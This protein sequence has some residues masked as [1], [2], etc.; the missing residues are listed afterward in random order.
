MRTKLYKRVYVWEFP[1]RLFHWINALAITVLVITGLFIADPFALMSNKEAY[2]TFLMGKFRFVHF[3]AAYILTGV[4]ILRL[5]WGF[6][7]NRY[8]RWK[9][10]F[11]FGRKKMKNLGHVIKYDVLSVPNKDEHYYE[12]LSIGHNALSATVYLV[13]FLLLFL[14]ILTGFGLY[15]NNAGWWFPKMFSWV[16][17]LFGGD[18]GM[19]LVHH[20]TMWLIILF[21]MVHIY[22]AIYH[23]VV[24]A[25]GEI[26][27]MVSGFKFVRWERFKS[28]RRN[29]RKIREVLDKTIEEEIFQ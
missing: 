23:D 4:F 12:E 9:S 26:S 15:S 8:A 29:A 1:V 16:G 28:Y 13:F 11:P 7:G 5:Y 10:F 20:A 6:V 18:F 17:P 27:S 14:M 3:V 22:M 19:R 24:E 2:E 21:V 25:R